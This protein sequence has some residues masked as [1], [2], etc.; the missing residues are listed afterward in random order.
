[1]GT[2]RGLARALLPGALLDERKLRLAGLEVLN[3]SRHAALTWMSAV[4][5]QA[6][7]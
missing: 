3:P 6:V 2:A 5:R 4:C 1:M 7:V